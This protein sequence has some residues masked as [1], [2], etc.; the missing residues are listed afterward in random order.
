MLY[1]R[2]FPLRL[3]GSVCRRYV[4]QA[5]LHESEAWCLMECEMG[6]LR[7]PERSMVG[8]MCGV[9]L[10]DR[11]RSTDLMFGLS[12]MVDQLAMPSSI[13]WYGLVL[14]REDSHVLRGALYF[15]LRVKGRMVG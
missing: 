3:K 4:W 2:R 5:I 1:G 6:V 10:K 13:H 8:A 7:R 12:E 15:R 9:Q 11:K 14:R